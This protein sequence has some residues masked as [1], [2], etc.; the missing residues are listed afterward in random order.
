[1]QTFRTLKGVSLPA[2]SCAL[3][4]FDGIHVGHQMVLENA[5]KVAQVRNI[6]SVVVSFTNHPQRLIS[7]TPTLL[8]SSMHERLETFETMGFDVAVLLEFNPWLKNL[9]AE[10]FISQI[11]L[12]HLGAKNVTVGYDHRFGKN[13]AGDSAMLT[14]AGQSAG[15]D[16][17]IIDPV[18]VLTRSDSQGY[19]QIVSST[20]IRKLISYGD[21]ELSNQLL[22]RPYQLTGTVINGL[23]RGRTIGFPTANLKVDTSRLMPQT[24]TY[25]GMAKLHQQ[26]YP[27]VCNIGT[28][29]TFADE[30]PHP[31]LEV[32]LLDYHSEAFYE[33]SVT[34]QFLHKVRNEQKFSSVEAL[35]NQIEQDC[36]FTR[37]QLTLSKAEQQ[38]A[39]YY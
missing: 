20:L 4:M 29:P 5:L 8:L 14:K 16:V 1:M 27:A 25:G 26:W 7:Q 36:L 38:N 3:G 12:E 9:S 32:H 30:N 10:Q 17:Q 35:K 34:M 19:G 39:G 22:G 28:C 21:I 15:F 33:A 23:A 2:S 11:L 37:H 31:R 6:P 24:A 13:R 18:K